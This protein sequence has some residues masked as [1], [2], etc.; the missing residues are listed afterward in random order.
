MDRTAILDT[1]T[2]MHTNKGTTVYDLS[3]QHPI[4][5]IFLRRFGC[6]FCR[7]AM[8]TLS[9]ERKHI[10]ALGTRII[11]VHMGDDATAEENFKQYNLPNIWHVSDPDAR[12][13]KDFGLLR[14]NFRQLFGLTM[15]MDGVRRGAF[16]KYG[17]GAIVGD[18]F[19]MPGAFMLQNGEIR[20][21]FVHKVVSDQPNYNE[22]MQCCVV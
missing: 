12:F 11:L 1:I 9:R 21:S 17:V 7:E 5:M 20:E 2:Q 13:Y 18:G 16:Q 22:M 19:Q 15:W 4:L 14:G 3:Y 10:E 6:T 8:D